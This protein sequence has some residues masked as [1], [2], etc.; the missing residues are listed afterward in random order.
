MPSAGT[1]AHERGDGP[2]T[3]WVAGWAPKADGTGA[4]F[5]KN[6][7]TYNYKQNGDSRT[8]YAIWTH[9]E[10]II[11]SSDGTIKAKEFNEIDTTY[12]LRLEAGSVLSKKLTQSTDKQ[13]KSDGLYFQFN[14]LP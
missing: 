1:L 10:N 11:I 12:P 13:V 2:N 8:M 9:S 14:E 4:E 7:A 5:W 3:W 6:G